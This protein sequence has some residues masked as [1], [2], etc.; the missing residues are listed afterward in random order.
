MFS[1]EGLSIK[2]AKKRRTEYIIG[3]AVSGKCNLIIENTSTQIQKN[4]FF[5]L[6]FGWNWKMNVEHCKLMCILLPCGNAP[7]SFDPKTASD[8]LRS[9]A[10]LISFRC[11][12]AISSMEGGEDFLASVVLGIKRVPHR[13]RYEQLVA[14]LRNVERGDLRAKQLAID[15]GVTNSAISQLEMYPGLSFSNYLK[16]IK[17]PQ[18]SAAIFPDADHH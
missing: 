6:H 10:G 11:I 8:N 16:S 1:L 5:A 4:D 2:G 17:K 14:I 12:E 7:P 15:L 13:K 3:K 18:E 9:L